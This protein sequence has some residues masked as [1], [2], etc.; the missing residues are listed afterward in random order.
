MIGLDYFDEW[1][2]ELEAGDTKYLKSKWWDPGSNLAPLQ[3]RSSKTCVEEENEPPPQKKKKK[4][5][6]PQSLCYRSFWWRFCVVT[7]FFWFFCGCRGFCHRTESDL[8]LLLFITELPIQHVFLHIWTSRELFLKQDQITL[9]FYFKKNYSVETESSVMYQWQNNK[10]LYR[11]RRNPKYSWELSISIL[12]QFRT[13]S[14]SLLCFLFI[15]FHFIVFRFVSFLFVMFLFISRFFFPIFSFS[16][17]SVF[18]SFLSGMIF[19]VFF[20]L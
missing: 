18:F 7:L 17:L 16:I 8:F 2:R 15:S 14:Y 10:V 3:Q 9:Q 4:K 11:N 20:F 6:G 19:R 1:Y 12:I 5:I 13:L